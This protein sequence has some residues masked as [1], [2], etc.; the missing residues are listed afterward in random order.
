M[1]GRGRSS[2]RL[3]TKIAAEARC[4]RPLRGPFEEIAASLKRCPDTKP[5]FPGN[6]L[7]QSALLQLL[8]RP[9]DSCQRSFPPQNLECFKQRR[10]IF[11]AANGYPNRL[12]HLSRFEPELLRGGA[13]GLV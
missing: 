9:I 6:L 11:A 8:N 13:Q 1:P 2:S 12:E 3:L 7:G 5:E 4:G 10:G